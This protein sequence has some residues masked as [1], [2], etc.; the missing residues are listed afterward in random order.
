[1]RGIAINGRFLGRS[2]SGVERYG[3]ELIKA[4]DARL[5]AG[6]SL[7]RPRIVVPKNVNCDLELETIRV[8][9]TSS[10]REGHAWEQIDLMR[11]ARDDVLVSLANS[12]PVRHPRHFV[13]IHDAAVYRF[14]ENYGFRYRMLH[15]GLGR[16]LSRT[17]QL[18]TVSKFSRG[19]LRRFLGVREED[20]VLVPNG[21]EHLARIVPDESI[22]ERLGLDGRPFFLTIGAA[23][24]NKNLSLVIKA[25]SKLETNGARLVMAGA[26]SDRVF[27][28]SSLE[29]G[30]GVLFPGKVSDGELA[31]LFRH[32][33]A[34]IFPSRYEGFGIP[35]LEAMS[36]GCPV[37]AARIPAVE[38]VCGSAVYYCDPDDA[39]GLAAL[40]EACL[41]SG[42]TAADNGR[43]MAARFSWAT[44]AER[45][46]VAV[47]AMACGRPAPI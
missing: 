34:L 29:C 31:G 27:S 7:P 26:A 6:S 28:G 15:R 40:I 32:A 22:V 18:V 46:A 4:W 10:C 14:P 35:P 42:R 25:W 8:E 16:L 17:A 37:I 9:V 38:E 41:K 23:S 13:V 5:A 3:R 12:G 45:L 39:D 24:H 30:R 1:M 2:I 43:I 36:N 47:E 11:A 33:T 44:S 19:E 21:S 20:V